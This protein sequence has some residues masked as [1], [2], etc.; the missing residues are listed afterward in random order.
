MAQKARKTEHSGAKHGGGAYWGYKVDAKKDSN[1]RRRH[2]DEIEIGKQMEILGESLHKTHPRW[3]QIAVC[4]GWM[5]SGEKC[6]SLAAW[7]GSGVGWKHI[8]MSHET[9]EVSERPGLDRDHDATG[10]G[11]TV[12]SIS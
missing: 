12:T 11:L 7:L 5:A 4:M 3:G 9:Y 2:N 6:W 10:P 1:T 8:V